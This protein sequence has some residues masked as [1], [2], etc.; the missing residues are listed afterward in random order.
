MT[1]AHGCRWLCSLLSANFEMSVNGTCGALCEL[2]AAGE[3]WPLEKVQEKKR[4]GQ[5][6]LTGA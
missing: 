2:F 3:R 1:G 4:E 6:S 5:Y